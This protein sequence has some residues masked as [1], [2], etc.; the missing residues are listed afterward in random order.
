MC[1]INQFCHT[2]S[3]YQVWSFSSITALTRMPC[4]QLRVEICPVPSNQLCFRAIPTHGCSRD[5]TQVMIW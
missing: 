3:T 2:A 5:V 1:K 4:H